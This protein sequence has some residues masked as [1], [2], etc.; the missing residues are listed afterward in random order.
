MPTPG[1]HH[2][3]RLLLRIVQVHLA[4]SSISLPFRCPFTPHPGGQAARGSTACSPDHSIISITS[5]AASRDASATKLSIW[6]SIMSRS[7]LG[8]EAQKSRRFRVCETSRWK[9]GPTAPPSPTGQPLGL[10][11]SSTILGTPELVA[12]A[13]GREHTAPRKLQDAWLLAP[14]FRSF[15]WDAMHRA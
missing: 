6:A 3:R 9:L 13:F 15:R 4:A 7:T 8:M 5:I 1:Q 14:L 10:D 12:I 11:Y 2:E